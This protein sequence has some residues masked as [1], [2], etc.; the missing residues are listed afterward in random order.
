MNAVKQCACTNRLC[1]LKHPCT[2]LAM[3]EVCK[4]SPHQVEEQ[5]LGLGGGGGRGGGGLVN[6]AL[7]MGDRQTSHV[8]NLS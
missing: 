8:L 4:W 2:E 3:Q 6:V 7:T 1:S 5:G